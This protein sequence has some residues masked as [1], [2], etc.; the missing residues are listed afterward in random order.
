MHA[1]MAADLPAKGTATPLVDEYIKGW[2]CPA[3]LMSDN[4]REL[5]NELP[6]AIPECVEYRKLTPSS[7]H[8]NGNEG[9]G[10]AN[11]TVAK[12]LVMVMDAKQ[13]V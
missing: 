2:G 11:H 9:V 1:V 4:G 12:I 3:N 7:Y 13:N 5:F 10:T 6:G 8:P